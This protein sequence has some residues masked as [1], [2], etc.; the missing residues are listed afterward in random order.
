MPEPS[1]HGDLYELAREFFRFPK[2]IQPIKIVLPTVTSS[3]KTLHCRNYPVFDCEVS[4][5]DVLC[6]MRVY[7]LLV[8][9]YLSRVE[10]EFPRATVYP[11]SN[12]IFVGGPATNNFVAA[13]TSN[14]PIRFHPDSAVR[15]FHGTQ[16]DYKV[17]FSEGEGEARSITEDY[18]LLSKSRDGEGVK[19]VIGGLRAYGQMATHRFLSDPEFYH[20]TRAVSSSEKGFQVLVRVPVQDRICPTWEI[21]EQVDT[22]ERPKAF[23]AYV[24]E[25]LKIVERLRAELEK[26]SI[27]VLQ[28][29]VSLKGSDDWPQEIE[30]LIRKCDFFIPCFSKNAEAKDSTHL[31]E[32]LENMRKE[33]WSRQDKQPGANWIIPVRLDDCNVP[34]LKIGDNRNLSRIHRIDLFESENWKAGVRQIVEVI[35]RPGSRGG[36]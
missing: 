23:I 4:P 30:R 20:Q 2:D 6:A 25:D 8:V 34:D 28:D 14:F 10:V 11:P 5:D 32:E 36:K 31:K 15:V 21:V 13:I 29:K 7:S 17:G 9:S 3:R 27:E 19:F 18:C 16:R 1:Q 33:D 26:R 35:W 24:S 22:L 12:G